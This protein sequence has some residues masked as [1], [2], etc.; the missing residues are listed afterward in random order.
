[1][2]VPSV[3]QGLAA[4]YATV[5]LGWLVA[6][7]EPAVCLAAV[8][9]AGWRSVYRWCH[10]SVPDD[11]DRNAPCPVRDAGAA[12]RHDSKKWYSP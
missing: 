11:S 12:A 5:V 6:T 1:M 7:A 9:S 10:V 8:P 2:T 4:V 3:W